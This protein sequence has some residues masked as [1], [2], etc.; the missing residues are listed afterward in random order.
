MIQQKIA[1]TE[2]LDKIFKRSSQ[3]KSVTL[4]TKRLGYRYFFN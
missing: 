3:N 1:A 4:C 2:I